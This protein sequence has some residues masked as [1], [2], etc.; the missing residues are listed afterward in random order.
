MMSRRIGVALQAG[1]FLD[2]RVEVHPGGGP[3]LEGL[4]KPRNPFLVGR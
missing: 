3:L 4:F 1:L 2:N